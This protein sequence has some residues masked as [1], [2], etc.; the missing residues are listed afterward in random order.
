MKVLLLLKSF[1]QEIAMASV[2]IPIEVTKIVT[3]CIFAVVR[4]LD[5][6]PE[7]HRAAL[8]QERA[9]KD[10]FGHDREILELGQEVRW[11]KHVGNVRLS[12]DSGF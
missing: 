3:G 1:Q 5:P 4:E 2:H 9:S 7:L 12:S 10:P 6:R 11:K 8:G